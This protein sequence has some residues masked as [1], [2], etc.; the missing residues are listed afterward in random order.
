MDADVPTVE[1]VVKKMHKD[2]KG[3]IGMKVLG[4]GSLTYQV[5]DCLKYVLGL[6]F[7]DSFTI[8]QEN[9]DELLDLLKKI[10]EASV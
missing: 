9:K 8:G 7:V 4:G 2:G 3:I 6:D 1:K 5:D 10:P